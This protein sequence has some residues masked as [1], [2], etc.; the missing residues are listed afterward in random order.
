[1]IREILDRPSVVKIVGDQ[2]PSGLCCT[3]AK[4]PALGS[5]AHGMDDNFVEESQSAGPQVL[6]RIRALQLYLAM[7]VFERCPVRL[8]NVV[9][10][11][12]RQEVKERYQSSAMES[13]QHEDEPDV[14]LTS[15]E[16]NEEVYDVIAGAQL[17]PSSV[18]VRNAEMTFLVDQ[19]N[20]YKYDTVDNYLK[21]TGKRSIPVK[22]VDMNKGDTQRPEVRSRLPVAE[23]RHRTTLTRGGQRADVFGDSPR[24][25]EEKSYVLMLIDITRAHPHCSMRRQ[26]WVELLQED[27]RCAEE[28]V[29][30]LLLRSRNGL[31][32]AGMQ[33]RAACAPGHGQDWASPCVF[34]HREE[35][36]AS[37]R[38]R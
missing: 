33:L 31:S 17:D 35:E 9:L 23:N 6:C 2:C 38:V 34:V 19:M 28:C 25:Q 11:V 16:Y 27:P 8:V 22:C 14:W 36:D 29:C 1:M 21:T 5:Q 20:A 10:R 12:Q 3:D 13:G 4:G 26:V 15:P 18:A 32:D 7:R 24:N 30:G 37:V